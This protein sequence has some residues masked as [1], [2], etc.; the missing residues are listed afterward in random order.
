MRGLPLP[1]LLP[2]A[3]AAAAADGCLL[4]SRMGGDDA[5]VKAG[6]PQ[7]SPTDFKG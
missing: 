5:A 2:A 6:I 3:E 1:Y 4:Y 7:S